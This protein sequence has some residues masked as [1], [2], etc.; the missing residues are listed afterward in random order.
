MLDAE[1][2]TFR[3][4]AQAAVGARPNRQ[5]GDARSPTAER[6]TTRHQRSAAARRFCRSARP[7]GAAIVLAMTFECRDDAGL[8]GAT[9]LQAT[10]ALWSI[11]VRAATPSGG[12]ADETRQDRDEQARRPS[13]LAARS[14]PATE[15]LP[16]TD[17]V[18]LDR[19]SA[20]D[21]RLLLRSG[22]R[23]RF[24]HGVHHRV[25]SPSAVLRGR[26]DC[27]ASSPT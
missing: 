25:A 4:T 23:E 2:P 12:A 7:P 14:S 18:G 6:S 3:P 5:A 15:R 24:R 16:V 20:H 10:R 19:R 11:G 9:R 27:C 21:G 8:F 26:R 17:R 22:R 1:T 13:P